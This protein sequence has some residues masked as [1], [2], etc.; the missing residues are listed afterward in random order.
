[1]LRALV[2]AGQSDPTAS[3]VAITLLFLALWPGLDASYRRLLRHFRTEPELLVSEIAGRITRNIKAMHLD[4]VN[5]IAA[6]LILNCERDIIR[7]LTGRTDQVIGPRGVRRQ[8][9]GRRPYGPSDAFRK[10]QDKVRLYNDGHLPGRT[11]A[12]VAPDYAVATLSVEDA[13][14]ALAELW[15]RLATGYSTGMPP[16]RTSPPRRSASAPRLVWARAPPRGRLSYA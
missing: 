8:Q 10:V 1:M 14:D 11:K 4:R 7:A 3:D 13:R 2:V 15:P 16:S 6:T 12:E 5:W 9:G